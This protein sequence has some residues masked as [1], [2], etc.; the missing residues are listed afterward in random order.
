MT[1]REFDPA[2]I[3]AK[4]ELLRDLLDDLDEVGAI[5]V[6][7]LEGDRLTRHAIERILTQLVDIAAGANVHLA[8]SL[9][10]R[11]PSDYGESFDLAA[12]VG[13]FTSDLAADLKPSVGLRNI[14]THEYVRVDLARVVDAVPV[15]RELY[16]EYVRQVARFLTEHAAAD[17]AQRPPGDGAG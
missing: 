16:G 2:S 10:P 8:A 5:D 6:D 3:Q 15:A 9:G 14:L 4:L 13:A 11:A 1:P 17:R 12:R 7:R